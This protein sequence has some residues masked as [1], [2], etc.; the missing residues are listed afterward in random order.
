MKT[1][2]KTTIAAGLAAAFNI[3][4]AGIIVDLFTEPVSGQSVSTETIGAFD[5][6]Q[7]GS[8]PASIIGGWRDISITKL[9]DTIGLAT[10]GEAS[11][12]QG[13]GT[14][15]IDNAA[16][17]T[18]RAVVTWDGS[19]VAGDDGASVKTNGLGDI[20][21]GGYDLTVGG[22]ANA[23]LAQILYADLGFDYS[24]RVWDMDGSGVA[25]GAGVQFGVPS[26]VYNSFYSF[27][28][29]QLANGD[30][31]DGVASPPFCS[32]PL[33]Q[34]DFSI[35]RLGNLGDIDFGHIG[36]LQIVF[37]NDSD[38]A[39]ADF[40]LGSMSTVPEPGTLALVGLGL[41]GMAGQVRRRR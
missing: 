33:T 10:V 24:I 1:L 18:S 29:F 23:F 37:E 32:N 31:C 35:T 26:G 16:G 39:S 2:T 20:F 3:A 7:V 14:L 27:D 25:L 5:T 36:A 11:F 41:L 34:L 9:T 13:A 38:H 21:A 28:W 15:S 4:H 12:S 30:Y 6:S 8:Y 19:N 22:S 17:V 40:A